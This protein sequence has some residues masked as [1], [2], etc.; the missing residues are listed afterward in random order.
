MKK[1]NVLLI[2]AMVSLIISCGH[3]GK[4][5]MV[6]LNFSTPASKSK[7]VGV[8]TPPES[9]KQITVTVRAPDMEKIGPLTV[10]M[11]TNSI[12]FELPAGAER[13]FDA[14]AYNSDK[15]MNY[16]GSITSDINEGVNNIITIRMRSALA[17]AS[18]FAAVAGDG[19][20]FLNWINPEDSAFAGVKIMRKVDSSPVDEYDGDLVY[21]GNAVAYTNKGLTNGTMYYYSIFVCDTSGNYSSGV[22]V[23]KTPALELLFFAGKDETNGIELWT[24]NGTVDGTR[25]VKNIAGPD[26]LTNILNSDPYQFVYYNGKTFFIADDGVNG[27]ELWVTDGTEAGTVM[28]KDIFPGSSGSNI[29]YMTV[30]N[31]KLYFSAVSSHDANYNYDTELWVTDGT[32][33]GTVL[34]KDI[35]PGTYGSNPSNLTV[36]N[37]KLYFAANDGIYGTELWVTDGTETGTAIVTDL[38]TGDINNPT[39]VSSSNPSNLTVFKNKLY[40]SAES[41]DLD[42]GSTAELWV[43]DGIPVISGGKTVMVADIYPLDSDNPANLTVFNNNL[44]FTAN[45]GTY[46]TELWVTDG[47]PVSSGGVTG[48]V[49][50]INPIETAGSNPSNFIVYNNML[51]FSAMDGNTLRVPAVHG[52][53]VWYSDGTIGNAS[54]IDINPTVLDGT[55]TSSSSPN[56]FIVYNSKL[57][58]TA[59]DGTNGRELWVTDGT[60][61]SMI[62]LNAGSGVI[63]S[64]VGYDEHQMKIYKGKLYFYTGTSS[65]DG[66][67]YVK[68]GTEN[69]PI[70]LADAEGVIGG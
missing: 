28:V 34:V 12:T 35:Y 70:K 67:F 5:G 6:T 21:I 61:T 1:F 31:N 51:Y 46:G 38:N 50:D 15:T 11:V 7:A 64:F 13:K 4:T 14:K 53:E 32:K 29:L 16:Q 42:L 30:Y 54:Y 18:S 27:R 20:V 10:D 8:N 40:F 52:L 69:P 19:E 36:F 2:I 56:H 66:R 62:E 39:P 57:Y 55:N 3:S 9:V 44:Y 45:D 49:K 24:T 63:N 37:N 17:D 47:T 60:N 25:I 33:A 43:S 58:F 23:Q 26:N 41:F 59:N 65:D 68:D 48:L 22:Q